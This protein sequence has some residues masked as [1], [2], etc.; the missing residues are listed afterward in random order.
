MIA[1][2][3]DQKE[4]RVYFNGEL[5][6]NEGCNPFPWDKPILDPGEKGADFT[7][8]QRALPAWPGYP[9]AEA[10]TH[11]EGFGGLLGGLAV[12]KRAL[13]AEELRSI[14]NKTMPVAR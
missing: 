14:Y 3:Y 9:D 5:D 4:I 2:T 10:P 7:V 1:F 6:A 12:Y 11:K 8:A 13:K